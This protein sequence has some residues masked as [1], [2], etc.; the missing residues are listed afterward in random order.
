M[1][2]ALGSPRTYARIQSASLDYRAWIEAVRAGRTFA[3]MGP[4]LLFT[5]NG[6]HPGAV[7]DLRSGEQRLWLHAET[8]GWHRFDRVEL[9]ANGKVV[10]KREAD[11]AQLIPLGTEV[12]LPDGGWLAARCV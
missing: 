8:R 12:V 11:G 6:Q 5:V 7:V 3:T 2:Q 9:L 10:A 4:L 1:Q